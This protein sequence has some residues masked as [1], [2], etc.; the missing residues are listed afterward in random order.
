MTGRHG[1]SADQAR[2]SDRTTLTP[3]TD[4]G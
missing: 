1:R 2:T 4:S 3:S